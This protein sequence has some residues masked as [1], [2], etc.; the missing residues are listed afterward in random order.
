MTQ[1]DIRQVQL[2]KG[3]ILSGIYTLLE[4]CG[5][6]ESQLKQVIVAGQFGAHLKATSLTGAG[7]LPRKMENRVRY[8]GN[9]SKSGAILCL[10]SQTERRRV[11]QIA[12]NIR[13]IELSQL[14]GYEDM[15]VQC[16]SFSS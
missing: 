2:A 10:L 13:Y 11:E 6:S 7:L 4:A 8:V 16:M 5:M 9:T 15:F 3:A 14:A 12:Q 1:Q